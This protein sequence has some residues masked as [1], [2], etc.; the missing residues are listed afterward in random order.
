MGKDIMSLKL[1]LLTRL[2]RPGS[3]S[4]LFILQI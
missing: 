2:N 1:V 4:T 3:K